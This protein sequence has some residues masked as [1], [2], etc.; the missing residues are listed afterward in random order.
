MDAPSAALTAH[1][2]ERLVPIVTASQSNRSE[3]G[4]GPDATGA[5]VRFSG[6]APCT[7]DCAGVGWTLVLAGGGA[8]A[9]RVASF[10]GAVRVRSGGRVCSIC[11]SDR[12][13]CR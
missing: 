13:S 1:A 10:A 6:G 9:V 12:R 3:A 5:I 7:I 4:C 2:Y 8:G 11:V